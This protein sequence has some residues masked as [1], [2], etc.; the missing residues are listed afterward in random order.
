[1]RCVLPAV[2]DD[3]VTRFPHTQQALQLERQCEHEYLLRVERMVSRQ[4]FGAGFRI[5]LTHSELCGSFHLDFCSSFSLHACC[6]TEK[7]TI[8]DSAEGLC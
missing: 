4:Y 5:P 3:P 1:M 6:L 7:C 2:R 8:T